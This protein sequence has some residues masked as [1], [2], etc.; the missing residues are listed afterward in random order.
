L[1]R[2]ALLP[3]PVGRKKLPLS[4]L[5]C[6]VLNILGDQCSL[7]KLLGHNDSLTAEK[8]EMNYG[9]LVRASKSDAKSV[10]Y[11]VALEDAAAAVAAVQAISAIDDRVEDLGRVSLA[12]L[13]S[14]DLMP[15]QCRRVDDAKK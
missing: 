1:L 6:A 12:L 11:I 9:R 4:L 13:K 15:G 8:Y 3:R 7:S 10:A 5:K 14:L 2:R